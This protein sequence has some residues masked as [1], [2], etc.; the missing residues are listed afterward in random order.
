MSRL[1]FVVLALTMFLSMTGFGL[2]VPLLP[3][4][5]RE[6]GAGS[7]E[8]GFLFSVTSLA[9]LLTLPFI[10]SLSDRYGRVVFLC[11]GL[12]LLFIA[13]LGLMMADSVASLIVWR[14]LQGLAF[15]MHLPVAQAMLGDMTPEG[16]EGKWM[17]Y[18]NSIIYAGLGAGPLVGGLLGD[19]LGVRNVFACSAVIML[20]S[21]VATFVFLKEPQRHCKSEQAR[22]PKKH[23]FSNRVILAVLTLQVSFGVITGMSMA[24][25]PVL[26]AES[27][28]L[29]ATAIGV[30]LFIRTPISMLQS[31]SGRFAD[32]H[33][34]R[35]QITLGAL[36]AS[37]GIGL[38]PLASSV[39]GLLLANA[40]LA[41][42]VVI[43]QPASSAYMVEQGRTIGMGFSMSLFLMA[44]QLGGGLGPVAAGWLMGKTSISSGF[45]ASALFNV[46]G[47]VM[48]LWLLKG[49]RK[50]V[51]ST[52]NFDNK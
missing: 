29:S 24:F 3:V 49:N 33:D 36:V 37:L 4:Y 27:L 52:I 12:T 46:V 28:A 50:Q 1:V 38:M 40:L 31:W 17:G 32:S 45:Y 15:S 19:W 7:V 42:G 47:L 23:I 8:V 39:S 14:S 41:L 51:Q 44:M 30:V 26:A 43:T 9:N 10:A 13:S 48:F 6:F 2:I 22:L 25:T 35:I 18:F 21:L 20:L 5:A 34:R 16:Q 11:S